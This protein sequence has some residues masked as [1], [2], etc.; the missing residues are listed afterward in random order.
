MKIGYITFE[1]FHGKQNIGSTRIRVEWLCRY[2]PEAKVSK[3]GEKYDVYVFQKVYW[4]EYAQKL[5]ELH[6]GAILILDLCD[7]DFLSWANRVKQ[8]IDL[9]DA[10]TTSTVELA[11][12]VSKLTDKPIWAIPDRLDLE[13]FAAPPK[14]HTGEAKIAAWFGYSENFPMLDSCINSLIKLGYTDLLVIASR[15]APYVLPAT[16]QGKIRLTNYPWTN[17]TV[18]DD[19]RR[20]DVVL[21]PTSGVGRFKYKSNNKTITAWALGLPVAATPEELELYKSPEARNAEVAKRQV[22]IKE[23]YDVKRSVVEMKALIEEIQN[24]RF[25]V[26]NPKA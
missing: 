1:Q 16:A 21:N 2:W 5:R 20:A 7:A 15:R 9:C 19:L 14:V 18:Y 13:L 22:E 4:I 26:V 25:G 3:M 24:V 23:D 6:P 10:V 11:K 12:F 17:E 8:M